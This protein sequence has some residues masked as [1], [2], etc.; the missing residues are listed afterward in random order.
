VLTNRRF[1]RRFAPAHLALLA[2]LVVAC[3]PQA[4]SG[5]GST[6]PAPAPASAPAVAPAASGAVPEWQ[7]EWDRTLAAARQEGTVALTM[8]PGALFRDWVTEFEQRYPG[9]KVEISGMTGAEATARILAER[10]GGQFLRDVH[11]GGAESANVALKPVGALQP[12]KSAL[13]LPEVLDDSKWLNGFDDGFS[14]VEGLYTYAYAV[15]LEPTVYVSRDFVSEAELSRVE[16]LVDPKWRGRMTLYDPRQAGKGAAD[17]GHF[18]QVRGEDWYRQLLAQEPVVT[19]DRRQQIEW[20]VRGRYPIG[21][22]ISNS[23]VPEFHQQG[24]GLSLLPLAFRTPMGA[25]LSLT[26]TMVLIDQPAHPNAAKIFVNWILSRD[27]QAAFVKHLDENSRRTDVETIGESKPLPG[28]EYP[29][30]VN[31]EAYSGAQRRAM[32]I[33]KEVLR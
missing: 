13:I 23:A 11:I 25:R 26:R 21:I 1:S 16:D 7:A 20:A 32:D 2:V 12:L 9:I 8:Q 5:S 27:G 30:S 28:V 6:A 3:A 14:D 4:S 31:K 10:R 33:A 29:P 24:V 17:S 18:V 15:N 19:S 22:A